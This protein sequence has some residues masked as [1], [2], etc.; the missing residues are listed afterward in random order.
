MAAAINN[1]PTGRSNQW[2]W[3]M[4]PSG[5]TITLERE[6][7]PTTVTLE[8]SLDNGVTWNEWVES[9]TSRSQVLPACKEMFIRNTS[10]TSTRFTTGDSGTV[11]NWYHFVFSSQT[12]CGGPIESLICKNPENA[13]HIGRATFRGLFFNQ[14]NLMNTPKITVGVLTRRALFQTFYGCTNIKSCDLSV[15]TAI[16]PYGC[17]EM[18]KGCTNLSEIKCG[19]ITIGTSGT[20][21]WLSGVSAT[22][23]F[24]CPQDLT[25]DTGESGIPSGWT[26]HD[27]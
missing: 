15:L 26:R 14:T 5:G 18:F 11:S 12:V 1:I 6:D 20:Y 27:L 9:G 24:Y 16:G 7:S 19:S 4:M 23:D 17:Y 3:F 8:I 25:I 22:G 21:K 13:E 10:E 2:L